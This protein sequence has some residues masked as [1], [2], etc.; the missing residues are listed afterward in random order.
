MKHEEL[1][2]YNTEN[3]IKPKKVQNYKKRISVQ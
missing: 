3:T 1:L 2:S